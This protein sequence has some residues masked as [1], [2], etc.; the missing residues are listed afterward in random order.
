MTLSMSFLKAVTFFGQ[1]MNGTSSVRMCIYACL[2]NLIH[3]CKVGWLLPVKL[4]VWVSVHQ[5]PKKLLN[6]VS[7]ISNIQKHIILSEK[8]ERKLSQIESKPHN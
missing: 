6:R 7:L 2:Y 1:N 3:S 8:E 5:S 4:L